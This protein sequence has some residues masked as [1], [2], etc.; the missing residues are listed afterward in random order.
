M[1]KKPKLKACTVCTYPYDPA[2]GCENP[3]CF[4]NPRVS[5][6]TK[7]RWRE[8]MAQS[9][10]EETERNRVLAIRNSCYGRRK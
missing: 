2:K 1:A 7:A 9:K 8:Q 6:E 5:E 4:E 10:A 3:A